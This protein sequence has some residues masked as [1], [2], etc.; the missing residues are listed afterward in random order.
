MLR[1]S[2]GK[3]V[4]EICEAL[5]IS[6]PLITTWHQWAILDRKSFSNAT[7]LFTDIAF[8]DTLR[9]LAKGHIRHW[10][11]LESFF[12]TEQS[13]VLR[14]GTKYEYQVKINS[15]D[16][17]QWLAPPNRTPMQ[18]KPMF[19][20]FPD[21]A[22]FV[23]SSKISKTET[24]F[25]GMQLG[26]LQYRL[27]GRDDTW[28]ST[29]IAV[30]LKC[31]NDNFRS[32]GLHLVRLSKSPPMDVLAELQLRHSWCS[33]MLKSKQGITLPCGWVARDE[34]MGEDHVIRR[35]NVTDKREFILQY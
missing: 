21:S 33:R 25:L 9:C 19:A 3:I 31:S 5:R 23:I 20:T 22:V 29:D 27:A 17:K 11:V 30:I 18:T 7:V 2:E 13:V 28:M 6:N 24:H 1:L 10:Y 4:G 35:V 34:L 12:K 8:Y 26:Y 32:E 15:A 16:S 14:S